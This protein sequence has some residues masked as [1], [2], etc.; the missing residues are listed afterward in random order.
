MSA[1][2]KQRTERSLQL[3]I[4][5][6]ERLFVL[7]LFAS[8]VVR[9]SH[10][11]GL[12]PYNI[13]A[14]I[15]EGLV[16]FFIVI[17]RGASSLTMRPLDWVVA[18]AGT[19]LPM[20]ARAGG[21]PLF[22]TMIGTVLMFAGLSLA[23]WAKASLRQSFGIA[24]ANRGPVGSGPYRGVRHP[25]YAG[26]IAVFFGFLFNNPLPWNFVLYAVAVVLMVGRIL[27][28]ENILSRDPV[29]ADYCA[30]VRY[31]LLPGFF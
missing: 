1:P 29:Y 27:A 14:L 10:T 21:Q 9:L 23:I 11:L 16:A 18:L 2:L 30:H 20:L 8:F 12:R 19:A 3:A 25:M 6:G 7:L 17:R 15:S 13:L 31:R 22:P 24:A 5:L 28:E 26:Y 4:D